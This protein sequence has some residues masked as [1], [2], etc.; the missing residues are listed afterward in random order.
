MI[1]VSFSSLKIIILGHVSSAADMMA[2]INSFIT[3]LPP[4]PFAL[5]YIITCPALSFVFKNSNI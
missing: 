3:A 4:E 1:G 5:F 2:P